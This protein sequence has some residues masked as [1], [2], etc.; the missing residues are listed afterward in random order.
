ML[1]FD[2]GLPATNAGETALLAVMLAT[3]PATGQAYGN[4][5][6]HSQTTDPQTFIELSDSIE[7]LELIVGET[8]ATTR[9]NQ[10]LAA[11]EASP[12][13]SL[14]VLYGWINSSLGGDA[15]FKG[16]GAT[17]VT[18][19]ASNE[20][21]ISSSNT[22]YS[23]GTGITLTGTTFSIGQAVGTTSNV[24][25]GSFGVGTAASGTSGEIRATNNI[26]AYYSS[27]VKFKENI[28]DIPN[29]TEIVVDI[30]GKLFDWSDKYIEDNGG[31]DGYFIQKSDFGVIAQ[32]VQRKFPR[33]V[34]VRPDGRLA[35]DYEKLSALAFA[36]IKEQESRISRL[37]ALVAELLKRGQ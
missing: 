12:D 22:T 30:G 4:I 35:V 29:A 37:E 32:D 28:V 13:I 17:T 33:A 15:T 24:Q 14:I 26:T 36:A 27:D 11:I 2:I 5:T 16:S 19:N 7:I 9:S 8:P 31:E 23:A 6:G 34:R 25:F 18:R 3:N 10:L 21:T 20:F 1:R